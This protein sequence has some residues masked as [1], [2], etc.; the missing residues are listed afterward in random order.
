MQQKIKS[1]IFILLVGLSIILFFPI[2]VNKVFATEMTEEMVDVTEIDFVDCPKE[3][4]VGESK[5]LSVMV[6]PIDAA[7]QNIVYYSSDENII[8]IDE[9]GCVTGISAGVAMITAQCGEVK[10]ELSLIVLEKEMDEIPV[11]DIEIGGYEEKLEVGRMLNLSV[12][13]L[14]ANATNNTVTYQSSDEEIATVNSLGEVKGIKE[15]EVAISVSAGGITKTINLTVKVATLKIEMNSTYL[16]LQI[17]ETY[18]LSAKIFPTDADQSITYKSLDTDIIS[19]SGGGMVTANKCGSGTVIV[20]NDDLS[21]AVTV[22]VNA[23]SE[24]KKTEEIAHQTEQQK[25]SEDVIFAEKT[26]II[27]K[28][29]LKCIYVQGE[30]ITIYG[31]GYTMQIDGKQIINWENELLTNLEFKEEKD[32]I[33]FNLNNDKKLCGNIHIQF[34]EDT[35]SGKYIYLYNPSKKKYE[36]LKENNIKTMDLDTEGKYL[37]TDKRITT[38]R[39]NKVVIAVSSAIILVLVCMYIVAK[40]KYWFW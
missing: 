33:S 37:I 15:G 11:T 13:V 23:G 5:L 35:I 40:K 26:P 24:K 7:D 22:I 21:T 25:K 4:E 3:I 36:L 32:G 38:G 39:I 6:T 20:A 17:G 8:T 27:T 31:S 1:I 2:A 18:Q 29:M 34:E 9:N 10:K 16:V 19:V 30:I 28:D 14:P 12:T